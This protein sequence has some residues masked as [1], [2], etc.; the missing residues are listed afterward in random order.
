MSYSTNDF[1]PI[2][3]DMKNPVKIWAT[4]KTSF[5][6]YI[7]DTK[8]R[9]YL[10][11]CYESPIKLSKIDHIEIVRDE[12]RFYFKEKFSKNVNQFYIDNNMYFYNENYVS[13]YYL[14]RKNG[15]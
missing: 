7:D 14:K 12:A 6:R 1:D 9:Y 4:S 15:T 2:W 3:S 10:L 8:Y 5:N 13:A 11:L